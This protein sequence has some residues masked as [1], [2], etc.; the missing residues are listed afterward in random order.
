MQFTEHAAV[1]GQQRGIPPSPFLLE[2]LER[3]GAERPTRGGAT[4]LFLDRPARRRLRRY[5]GGRVYAKL[6]PLIDDAYVVERDDRAVTLGH[7]VRRL[8]LR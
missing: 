6:E 7:R 1:R 2:L 4:S 5:L 8:R 3:F